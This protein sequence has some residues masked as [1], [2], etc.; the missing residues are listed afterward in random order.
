MSEDLEKTVRHHPDGRLG[1]RKKRCQ[2]PITASNLIMSLNPGYGLR[3]ALL[4]V[5]R[6]KFLAGIPVSL[7]ARLCNTAHGRERMAISVEKVYAVRDY[8]RTEFPGKIVKY[9]FEA[10]LQ[11]Y[12]FYLSGENKGVVLRQRFLEANSVSSLS[13]HLAQIGLSSLLKQEY[14]QILVGSGG[15]LTIL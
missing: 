11:V 6:S 14:R 9:C 2:V 5:F 3:H 1:N 12:L 15:R 4:G 7:F 8:F 10:S 13:R